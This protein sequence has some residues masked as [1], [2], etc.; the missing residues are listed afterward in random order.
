MT[1][2]VETMVKNCEAFNEPDSQ[3]VIDAIELQH[4]YKQFYA[5]CAP[6]FH[7]IN[8]S[9]NPGSEVGVK[10]EFGT[11]IG[12]QK[13]SKTD[14]SEENSPE[15]KV[16]EENCAMSDASNTASNT[17]SNNSLSVK[18]G[19]KFKS[20]S[21]SPKSGSN[22]KFDSNPS[23][24]G[25]KRKREPSGAAASALQSGA[26]TPNS[27]TQNS[28]QNSTASGAASPKNPEF[29]ED[30]DI[31]QM[32]LEE[33][34]NG[35]ITYPF[36]PAMADIFNAVIGY[37]MKSADGGFTIHGPFMSLPPRDSYP[38]YFEKIPHPLSLEMV[39][40]RLEQQHYNQNIEH[41]CH[42]LMLIF[43]NAKRYNQGRKIVF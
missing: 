41:L 21:N 24:P 33:D 20:F 14:A 9:S 16:K 4:V 36:M 30:D 17:A 11:K 22:P 40:E 35:K 13:N 23:T 29:D 15:K 12:V 32:L 39:K 18:S 3:L 31:T 37:T 7:G 8:K 10:S 43:Q 28:I 25:S 26:L 19:S 42:D 2:D 38:D 5:E 6:E 1:K 27:H 34:E